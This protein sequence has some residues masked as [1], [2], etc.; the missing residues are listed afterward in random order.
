MD[1]QAV[2]DASAL[3]ERALRWDAD[4]KGR[5]IGKFRA[6]SYGPLEVLYLVLP[7]DR[8]VRIIQVKRVS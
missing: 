5:P 7:D 1:R 4:N 2:A 6:Y 3:I 8:M